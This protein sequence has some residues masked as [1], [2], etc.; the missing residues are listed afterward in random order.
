MEVRPRP[1]D[2]GSAA[3]GRHDPDRAHIEGPLG[4][5]RDA[6]ALAPRRIVRLG[7]TETGK[8]H[9]HSAAEFAADA[10]RL[11]VAVGE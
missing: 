7:N 4:D 1:T 3:T 8:V 11:A 5:G 2:R 10:V 9:V 6:R